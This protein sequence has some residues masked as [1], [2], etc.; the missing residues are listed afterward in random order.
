M[1]L[2]TGADAARKDGLD[3]LRELLDGEIVVPGDAGWDDARQAWN[4]AVD[5]RPAAVALPES[6]ADVVAV[7]TFAR[8]S[9]LRV[10]P[11]GTGH[12]AA[13]LGALEDTI[14]R[15][16]VPYARRLDRPRGADGAR[17]G[18]RDLARRRPGRGR[19]RARSPARLLARRRRRRLHARRRPFAG[20]RASTGWAA[21]QVTAIEVVTAAGELVRT[22][23]VEERDLFWALRGGGGAF[24]VVTAIEFNLF[25]IEQIHAGILWSPRRARGR[26]AEGVAR[27]DRGGPERDDLRRPDSPV[28]AHPRPAGAGAGQVVRRG[29]GVL[30]RRRGRGRAPSLE[31]LRALGPVLDT[32]APTPMRE[33]WRVH[34]DPEQPVPGAGDGQLLDDVDDG[35]IDAIVERTIGAPLLSVEL[36]HLGGEIA[37]A[38]SHHG[39]LAAFEAPYALYTVGIA[40]G[41]EARQ[42][43]EAATAALMEAVEPWAADHTYLNFAETRRKPAAL[44][45]SASYHRLRRIKAIVDP[46]DL[47][48]STIRFRRLRRGYGALGL[49]ESR[50]EGGRDARLDRHPRALRRRPVRLPRP[51]RDP[52]GGRSG[53]AVGPFEQY[54]ADAEPQQGQLS[55]A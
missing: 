55:A 9:G 23:W 28:S 52:R 44:F 33:L 32:V 50:V 14:L 6:A 20:S 38:R 21:N 16:T 24:G 29:A 34:M 18:G 1:E 13:A 19:P 54:A 53:R 47:I 42:A 37:C 11:Q 35:L 39:A 31:P 8:E 36:R 22:D 12:G 3:S 41:P 4:L 46:K 43:V 48:R 5:Q 25:P 17:R 2:V 30:A 45:S 10:A 49:A 40:P 26:G 51:R 27:V 15:K 7:V